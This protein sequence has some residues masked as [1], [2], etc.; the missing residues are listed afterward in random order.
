VEF[1]LVIPIFLTTTLAVIEFA[2]VFNAVLAVNYASRTA[3][4]LA[5]EAG[6][7]AGSDCVILRSIERDLRPPSDAARVTNVQI[8]RST[9]AGTTLGTPTTYVRSGTTTCTFGDGTSISVPYTRTANG[10]PE[11]SRCNVLA[12]CG[13]GSPELDLVG[14]E[15][16]YHHVWVTPLRA[17]VGGDPGGFGFQRSNV[18]R[19]EP[20]L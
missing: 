18:M 14:V 13:V 11:A 5:A 9:E 12:G 1:A 15:V 6:N 20:V 19:M 8:F 16:R 7:G 4:L 10:Y 2:F 3:A 17:F